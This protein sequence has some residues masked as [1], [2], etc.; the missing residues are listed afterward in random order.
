MTELNDGARVNLTSKGALNEVDTFHSDSL[1]RVE[2]T[3]RGDNN[4][5]YV[6]V[7]IGQAITTHDNPRTN[8]RNPSAKR[9]ADQGYQK[10]T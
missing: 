1:E 2:A 6:S 5:H 4:S 3:N 8:T 9:P 7:K 10:R